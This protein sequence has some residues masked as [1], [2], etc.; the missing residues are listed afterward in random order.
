METCVTCG[1]ATDDYVEYKCPSCGKGKI[2][3]CKTC[4]QNENKYVCP[5]CGFNG[6]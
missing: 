1:R 2:T 4:R 5:D 3:R 6:P